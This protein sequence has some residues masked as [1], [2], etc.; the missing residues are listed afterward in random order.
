MCVL[1][2]SLGRTDNAKVIDDSEINCDVPSISF[3]GSSADL[4]FCLEA[5]EHAKLSSRISRRIGL[6]TATDQSRTDTVD[7]IYQ[8]DHELQRWRDE[9]SVSFDKPAERSTESTSPWS[10]SALLEYFDRCYHTSVLHLHSVVIYPWTSKLFNTE[11]SILSNQ[12]PATFSVSRALS[13]ARHSILATTKLV[14]CV[15]SLSS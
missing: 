12:R 13:A 7:D 3:P 14:L 11:G 15:D 4:T 6:A 1:N 8:L 5:I 10:K 9:V 2:I